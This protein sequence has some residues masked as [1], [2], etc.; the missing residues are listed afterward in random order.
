MFTLMWT[1]IVFFGLMSNSKMSGIGTA[2]LITVTGDVAVLWIFKD[3]IIAAI[4]Q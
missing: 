3:A 4:A 2:Y 1:W